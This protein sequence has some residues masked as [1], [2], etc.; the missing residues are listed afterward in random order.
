MGNLVAANMQENGTKFLERSVPTA[1]EKREDGK[2]RVEWKN[3]EKDEM[4]EDSFDTVMFAIGRELYCC[5]SNDY[6]CCESRRFRTKKVS[7][8]RGQ[9]FR[10]KI[11]LHQ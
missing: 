1:I 6:F 7:I 9:T 2:L 5:H 4:Q 10:L 8:T 3:L 11:Y